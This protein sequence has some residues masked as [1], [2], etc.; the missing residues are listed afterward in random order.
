MFERLNQIVKES[1]QAFLASNLNQQIKDGAM[2]E[3]TG[4]IVDV[5]KTQLDN[6]KANDLMSYFKNKQ[7]NYQGL[8]KVMVNKYSHRL[9]EYFN[10]SMKDSRELSEQI[11]PIVMSKFVTQ[12]MGNKKEENGLFNLMN[13]LSGNTV[14]FENFFLKLRVAPVA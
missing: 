9:N 10:L 13:W 14:N 6:G 8:T 2:Y 12:T 7:S 4:V 5:L 1:E 3:A 11:I